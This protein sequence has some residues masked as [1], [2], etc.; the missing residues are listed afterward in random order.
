MVVVLSRGSSCGPTLLAARWIVSQAAQSEELLL[1]CGEDERPATITAGKSP[2]RVYHAF[3]P[4]LTLG[5]PKRFPTAQARLSHNYQ[6]RPRRWRCRRRCPEPT[7]LLC[8]GA[9][10]RVLEMAVLAAGLD[11]QRS[12]SSIA[13]SQTRGA[14]LLASWA[15]MDGLC[16][17]W[18]RT[19]GWAETVMMACSAFFAGD[20]WSDT[21]LVGRAE[22]ST[23]RRAPLGHTSTQAPHS[24][25]RERSRLT[26]STTRDSAPFGQT[27]THDPHPVHISLSILG[28]IIPLI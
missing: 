23:G 16:L 14:R 28:I 15:K 13:A 12:A 17:D 26:L 22:G 5:Q 9:D 2:I 27:R 19:A 6:P 4:G 11:S 7:C 20:G 21:A 10:P 8:V 3:P 24:S 18:V 1:A 25:H